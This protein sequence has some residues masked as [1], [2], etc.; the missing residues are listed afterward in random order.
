MKRIITAILTL[1]ILASLSA[2]PCFAEE[3]AE[4]TLLEVPA[5]AKDDLPC[6]ENQETKYVVTK[7]VKFYSAE[8]AK[9]KEI[10]AGYENYIVKLVGNE[11]M[12]LKLDFSDKKIPIC[13]VESITFRVYLNKSIT[14]IRLSPNDGKDWLIKRSLHTADRLEW[15]EITIAYND[16]GIGLADGFYTLENKEGNLGELYVYFGSSA[17][18]F[19]YVDSVTVNTRGADTVAPYFKCADVSE[20]S[21]T[22][23]KKYKFVPE[24]FDE[25]ENRACKV[26]ESWDRSPFDEKKLLVKGEYTC[27]LTASDTAGNKTQMTYKLIV[28]DRDTEAPVIHADTDTVYALP[29]TVASLH[30]E[31]TDNEDEPTV[32]TAWSKDA[33]DSKGRF[34]EGTHTYTVKA[35]DETGNET[36]RVITVIVGNGRVESDNIIAE[37]LPKADNTVLIVA[38]A[39]SAAVIAVLTVCLIILLPKKKKA[40]ETA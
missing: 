34:V 30:V 29:G 19:M 21:V 23:E 37:S 16:E 8:E 18:E 35:T 24:A 5:G 6:A 17:T 26:E 14:S 11:E 15:K 12:G 28:R 25:Y 38:V 36:T 9:K 22:A 32:K 3:E 40:G 2:L 10:P 31:V 13:N 27:T 39:A 7:S 1:I 33:A 20:I 4:S